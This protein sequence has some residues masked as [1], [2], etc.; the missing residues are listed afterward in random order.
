MVP[1]AL[2]S[3]L[4]RRAILYAEKGVKYSKIL[5]VKRKGTVDETP[6]GQKVQQEFAALLDEITRR[7]R[8]VSDPKQIILFGSTARNQAG[9]GSDV[10]LLV[11]KDDVD[12]THAEA[13]R[14]YR[15]LADLAIPI[16]VVVMRSSTVQRY[17]NLVGTVV[18]PALREGKVLYER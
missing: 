18:R 4:S 10:D 14:I 9:A 11:I 15:A 6:V 3:F 12:A 1:A 13:A 7:I 2:V 8:A 17:S 16:D 5:Y